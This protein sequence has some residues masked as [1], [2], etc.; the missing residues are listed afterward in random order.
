[1]NEI[2][3]EYC[4]SRFNVG[5]IRGLGYICDDCQAHIEDDADREMVGDDA[6]YLDNIGCK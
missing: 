2:K 4:D 1:M 5:Y 6:F 3:C